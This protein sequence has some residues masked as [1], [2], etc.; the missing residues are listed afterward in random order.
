MP[1]IEDLEDNLRW[2]L[3]NWPALVSLLAKDSAGV[4]RIVPHYMTEG[5][6]RFPCVIY[7][8]QESGSVEDLSGSSGVGQT[9]MSFS[10][11]ARTE[12]EA[13]HIREQV[14]RALQGFRGSLNGQFVHGISVEGRSSSYVD[15]IDGSDRGYYIRQI[16][17]LITHE[18]H[19][20]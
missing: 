7:Q 20:V 2:R 17:V 9:R 11:C 15:P 1:V 12:T 16:D 5:K 6:D 3:L 10:C 13:R 8:E 19:E 14:R 4:P 18:E